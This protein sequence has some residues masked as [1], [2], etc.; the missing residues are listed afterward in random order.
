MGQELFDPYSVHALEIDFYN[1]DYDSVLQARW[2]E[3]D[4]SYELATIIF[5][6]ETLDSV[7]VRY[8]GNSTFWWARE[9][10]N[11]KFPLNLEFDL[12]YD[13]QDLLGYSKVKLSNSIFDPTF[14]RETMGYLSES[15]YLPTPSTGYM[16]VTANGE[17]LGLYISVESINKTFLTK[18]F[19]N[20]TG[21]FFK[22]EPQFQ[23]GEDYAYD[24]WPDLRWYGHDSTAYAYRMGY[25]LKTETGWADLLN[26]IYTL[27]FEIDSIETIL[28]VDRVLWFFAASTVMPDLDAY[29]GLYMHNYYLY[30]NTSSGQFEI[31]PWDKDQTFG[32]AQ[33]NTVRELGGN[34]EWIY[35][36]D[37]FLFEDSREERPLFR[38]LMSVPLYKKR[39]TAHMRTIIEDIYSVEYFE[40]QVG[41]IQDIIEPYAIADPNPFPS[42]ASGDY[43]R[44]NV[45]NY[46]VTPDDAHWCGITSTVRERLKYLLNHAEISKTAPVISK[47]VQSNTKPVDGETV[48][49]TAET[50]GADL[51]ELLVTTNDNSGLFISVPMV[52]DGTQGDGEAND[53][54]FGATVPFEAGGSHVK[55]YI[56]A[57]NDDALVL[58]P[59]KAQ[60]EL[61]EYR[62]GLEMLPPETVVIN[63]INYNSSNDF[64]PEDW[65]ELYNPTYTTTDISRWL[66]KD[67]NDDHVYTIPANT[68]LGPDQYL[69]LSK[70]TTA[71]KSVFPDVNDYIGDLGFGLSGGGELIRLFDSNGALMDMVE[72]DDSAPWPKEA[73]GNGPTLELLNPSYDNSLAIS[74]SASEGYGSP[75]RVNTRFVNLRNDVR[76]PTQFQVFDNFPNPFNPTTTISYELPIDGMVNI[77][78]Y[79]LVGRTVKTFVN[80]KQTAGFK[81]YQWNATNDNGEAVTAGVYFYAVTAGDYAQT[82]KMVLLK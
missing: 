46:L 23:Y 30:K 68:T 78:I 70:D 77:T 27:N 17:L 38:Q 71:F 16:N 12:I 63:E 18:H 10:E 41:G 37:P 76:T 49:I 1:P 8:K 45:S 24:A 25:E 2:K 32:G 64:D 53:N 21:A 58:S 15:Y 11:P 19:G 51:V 65:I 66:F 36:W 57:S 62:V 50:E 75:G 22:C 59:R 20:N 42:F 40:D 35:N 26:L 14:V 43:F 34:V 13:N 55:Y 60:T 33:I 69:V 39:Y 54:L 47:V 61:Y 3:D 29:T 74:W 52:D 67:E 48:V 31:I 28:N 79:D 6:G 80:G 56:R 73:D 7:G 44:Y 9:T 5:N 81:S 72:Y 4:K 82:K